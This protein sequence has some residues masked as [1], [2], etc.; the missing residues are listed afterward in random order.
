MIDY[1]IYHQIHAPRVEGGRQ[2]FEIVG[3]AELGIKRV[4]VGLPVAVVG[5]WV[6]D[7]E[8]DW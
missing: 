6:V 3:S 4:D 5:C 2:S 8:R 7:I 1:D